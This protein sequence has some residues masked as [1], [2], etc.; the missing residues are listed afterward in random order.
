MTQSRT[1]YE[2]C[3]DKEKE[4]LNSTLKRKIENIY[5]DDQEEENRDRKKKDGGTWHT[6]NL[7]KI[8]TETLQKIPKHKPKGKDARM[9]ENTT[10]LLTKRNEAA[11]SGN[12]EEFNKLTKEFRKKQ[13]ER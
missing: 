10:N 8:L 12:E 1:K 4:D 3:N 2:E 11:T 13:K 9:S 6:T 5:L 7:Q